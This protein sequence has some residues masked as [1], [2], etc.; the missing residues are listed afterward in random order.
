MNNSQ[1]RAQLAQGYA[2]PIAG[3]ALGTII[4]LMLNDVLPAGYE[5]WSWVVVQLLLGIALVIGTRASTLARN[6]ELATKKK[7]NANG[8]RIMNFVL[9]IIW[10]TVVGISSL[11]FVSAAVESLKLRTWIENADKMGGYEKVELQSLT[12]EVFVRDF[13]PAGLLLAIFVLGTLLWL[14]NRAREEQ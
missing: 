10:S 2:M 3:A 8:A 7:I 4:G 6:Y 13:L 9:S 12:L 1:A 14:V 5:V 11:I